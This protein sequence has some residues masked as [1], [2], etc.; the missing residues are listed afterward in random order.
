MPACAA[1]ALFT[2]QSY[3]CHKFQCG[4]AHRT[5]MFTKKYLGSVYL[6]FQFFALSEISEMLAVIML[7]VFVILPSQSLVLCPLFPF[8]FCDVL[9][10]FWSCSCPV[11]SKHLKT[12]LTTCAARIIINIGFGKSGQLSAESIVASAAEAIRESLYWP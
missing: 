8:L 6:V 11:K 5:C 1:S 12:E 7:A 4:P 2:Y 9:V 3:Q 10:K